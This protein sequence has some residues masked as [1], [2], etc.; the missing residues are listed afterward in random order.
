MT[1][2][3]L[4][5]ALIPLKIP[6]LSRDTGP[7]GH[8]RATRIRTRRITAAR[9]SRIQGPLTRIL[10]TGFIALL[11]WRSWAHHDLLRPVRICRERGRVPIEARLLRFQ[12]MFLVA[13]FLGLHSCL[14]P[15]VD[16]GTGATREDVEDHG[17]DGN[18]ERHSYIVTIEEE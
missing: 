7:L 3:R 16:L 8:R 2:Q 18:I 6:P 15:V 17:L 4:I 1:P 11:L 9:P 5:L 12:S 10:T 13:L 14:P